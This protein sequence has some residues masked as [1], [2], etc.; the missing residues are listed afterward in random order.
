MMQYEQFLRTQDTVLRG[1]TL[2]VYPERRMQKADSKW[3][4]VSLQY[5]ACGLLAHARGA[6]P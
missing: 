1:V 5:T 3:R 4:L 2:H 6:R